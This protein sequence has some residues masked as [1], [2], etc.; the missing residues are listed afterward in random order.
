MFDEAQV[1]EFLKNEGIVV[2]GRV[3]PRNF[4]GIN[5]YVFVEVERDSRNLQQPSN[6]TLN[7][8]KDALAERGIFVDFILIDG[9]ARDI[10]AGARASLLHTFHDLIS[11]AFVSTLGRKAH[12]W[13][14]TKRK[15]EDVDLEAIQAVAKVYFENVG[16]ELVDLKSTTDENLPSKTVCLKTIRL[17]APV[18]EEEIIDLLQQ[19]GFVVPSVNWMSKRLDLLRKEGFIVRLK[20]GNYALSLEGLSKLG[21]LKS[22]RSPDISRLLAL[23]RQEQ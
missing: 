10:E 2:S 15:L 22:R 4:D 20:N 19:S 18:T 12:L 14:V 8:L 7:R 11:N 1:A 13:L 3:V 6:L 23:A 9:T 21:T 16:F 17:R 5:F